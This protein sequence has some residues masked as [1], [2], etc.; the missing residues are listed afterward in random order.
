LREYPKLLKSFR[1]PHPVPKLPPGT[2]PTAATLAQA[3]NS[4]EGRRFLRLQAV[5]MRRLNEDVRST[6]A[7]LRK[8]G[9]PRRCT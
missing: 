8:A 1:T 3:F 6:R 9:V 2:G 4:A 7:V 5:L